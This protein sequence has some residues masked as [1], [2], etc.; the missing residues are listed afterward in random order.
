MSRLLA[1]SFVLCAC[2]ASRARSVEAASYVDTPSLGR[3]TFGI[4]AHVGSPL[5]TDDGD[6]RAAVI[7]GG[8]SEL[9][10][11][12]GWDSGWTLYGV[13]GAAKWSSRGALA[14][15]LRDRD[16]SILEGYSGLA[17][18]WVPN[19]A[20]VGPFVAASAL[21]DVMRISSPS[22]EAH[23]GDAVGLA[24]GAQL[25][26]RMRDVT[27]TSGWEWWAAID[28]RHAR[29]SAPYDDAERVITTRV[30]LAI[31]VA[32]DGGLR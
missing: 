18:R 29:L 14:Q 6:A 26:F 9:L 3:T 19:D 24:G 25:G 27:T 11:G 32:W 31:G 10:F 17:V 8:G 16:A 2:V 20:D 15:T 23:A 1:L 21:L 13:F 4:Q 12:Y 30:A 22:N 7:S 5:G 28:V